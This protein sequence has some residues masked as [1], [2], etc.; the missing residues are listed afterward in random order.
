MPLPR[1]CKAIGHKWVFKIK[2][3]SSSE[4]TH[5]KGRLCA[6]GF[7]QKAGLNYNEIF[8]P[9]VR[10]D[11]IRT[12]LYVAAVNNLEIYQFDVKSAYLNSNI[13][14]EIYMRAPEGLDVSTDNSVCK[15]NK[16]LYGLKQAGRC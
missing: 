15:L 11:S 12:L 14:E 16:A 9:I 2:T 10:Y 6:Q 5:Y 3:T 13:E 8:S 1:D 7:S 4:V